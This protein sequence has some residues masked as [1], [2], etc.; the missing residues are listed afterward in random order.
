MIED[1]WVVL[2]LRA[3]VFQTLLLLISIAIESVVLQRLLNISR[4][5]ATAY[6]AIL[7]LLSTFIGWLCFFVIEALTPGFLQTQLI[8][9]IFFDRFV[10][11]NNFSFLQ[12]SFY[13]LG[14]RIFIMA[15]DLTVELIGL[16][17]LLNFLVEQDAEIKH[18][19]SSKET[20]ETEN[21][22]SRYQKDRESTL[23]KVKFKAAFWA[24]FSS[25]ILISALILAAT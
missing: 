2:P 20:E 23:N 1:L 12:N 17:F 4:K 24:N 18:L 22:K 15:L 6:S 3:V 21:K 16:D 14:I 25:N 10:S 5:T 19:V 8:R 11:P 7:N 13:F 9:Y